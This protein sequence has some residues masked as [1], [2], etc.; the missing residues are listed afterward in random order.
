MWCEIESNNYLWIFSPML[1]PNKLSH[2]YGFSKSSSE[3]HPFPV[4]LG[5]YFYCAGIIGLEPM[6]WCSTGTRSNQLNYI[7]I[8]KLFY[9]HKLNINH[10]KISCHNQES[11]PDLNENCPKATVSTNFTIMASVGI[12]FPTDVLRCASNAHCCYF[13]CFVSYD[14]VVLYNTSN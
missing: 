14:F 8:F 6:I 12:S 10:E 5:C 11:N 13:C 2:H 7:P 9:F 1:L 4:Y 3:C